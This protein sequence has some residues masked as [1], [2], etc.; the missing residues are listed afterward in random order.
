MYVNI[1]FFVSVELC[2]KTWKHLR[3]TFT[4]EAKKLKDSTDGSGILK[5]KAWEW[6]ESM[7]FLLPFSVLSEKMECNSTFVECN[8]TLED[9]GCDTPDEI[10]AYNSG[11]LE[12]SNSE[13]AEHEEVRPVKSEDFE[14]ANAKAAEHE[15]FRDSD[16][17]MMF[18]KS[19]HA[20][21]KRINLQKKEF[22]KLK[23]QK[24]VYEAEFG[25][26]S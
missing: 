8:S 23:I 20:A 1:S 19:Q 2:R 15:E 3:D 7:S 21:F 5:R 10:I 26:S 6:F 13:D 25:D 14:L 16:E 12:V 18:L 22:L 11:N 9:K 4:K 24:L 17:D